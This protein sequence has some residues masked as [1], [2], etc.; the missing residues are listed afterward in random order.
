MQSDIPFSARTAEQLRQNAQH[1]REAARTEA[2]PV[3]KA[4]LERL[5]A[6]YETLASMQDGVTAFH[7][8]KPVVPKPIVGKPIVDCTTAR[9][10]PPRSD[11]GQ[12]SH[13]CC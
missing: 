2:N 3:A 9:V 12:A 5:A 13:E 1:Y 10:A 6:R 4:T 11:Q 7:T 8:A